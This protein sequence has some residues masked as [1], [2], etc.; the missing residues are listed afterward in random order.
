MHA[1]NK[2]E[3]I[4]HH[5]AARRCDRASLAVAGSGRATTARVPRTGRRL[6][7]G[8]SVT[9]NYQS[10]MI[11]CEATYVSTSSVLKNEVV[12]IRLDQTLE[13]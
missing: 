13:I 1:L 7:F 10:A 3:N 2:M 12:F 8:P 11:L 4:L 6:C 9:S 5:A